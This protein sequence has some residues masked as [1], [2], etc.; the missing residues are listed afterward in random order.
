MSGI[1]KL[2]HIKRLRQLTVRLEALKDMKKETPKSNSVRSEIIENLE[3]LTELE[4]KMELK[5]HQV[6]K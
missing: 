3:I 1:D 4:F 6:K 5:L 2:I